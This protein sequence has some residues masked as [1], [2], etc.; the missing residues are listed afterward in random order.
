MLG[1]LMLIWGFASH[2]E[3]QKLVQTS[4][5]SAWAP[6]PKGKLHTSYDRE[7]TWRHVVYWLP[8]R[9]LDLL[10]I[11]RLDLGIGP[12][13]GAVVRISKYAQVGVRDM[14]PASL[15][16]GL[17]GRR[18]PMML[19]T[20]NEMGIGPGFSESAQRQICKAEIGLGIDP[21]ILGVYA[22]ICLDEAFDFGVGLFGYDYLGDDL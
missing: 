5:K 16:I 12:A 8:N 6:Y 1:L 14:N 10:D 18:A 22:G 2:A 17:L 9:L 19:E 15:R 3:T 4:P 20:S 11:F 7:P 13:T 21:I